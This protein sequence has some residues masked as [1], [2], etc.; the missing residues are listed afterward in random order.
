MDVNIEKEIA[1]TMNTIAVF[2]MPKNLVLIL[3][4]SFSKIIN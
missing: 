2:S 3:P 4:I 1:I